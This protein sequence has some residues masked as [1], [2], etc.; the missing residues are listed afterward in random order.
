[1]MWRADVGLEMTGKRLDIEWKALVEL[2]LLPGLAIVLPWAICFRL[3][4]WLCSRFDVYGD[5]CRQALRGAR[6]RLPID[7][8]HAWLTERRLVTL[9]DHADHYLNGFRSD[10]WLTKHVQVEGQWPAANE[11]ALILTYHWGAGMWAL[12]HAAM[13]G[14]H[15]HMMLGVGADHGSWIANA[16]MRSRRKGVEGATG[17]KVVPVEFAEQGRTPSRKKRVDWAHVQAVWDQNEHLLAVI[18]VPPDQTGR[19]VT[20]CVNGLT[21]KAPVLLFERC[22]EQQVPLSIFWMSVDME[23]G[24]RRLTIKNLG[25]DH[26]VQKLVRATFQQ[27]TELLQ[28]RPA[29]WHFWSIADR[30]YC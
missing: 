2:V 20:V 9:V 15:N 8:E 27:L 21:A 17:R 19:C 18:D 30:Y 13:L 22:V 26:D 14:R 16:Y 10:R 24:R 28:S 7:D 29:S 12:R 23:T 3:Y 5:E 6:S 11:K 1:M 4:R 25:T